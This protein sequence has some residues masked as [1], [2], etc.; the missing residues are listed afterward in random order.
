MSE[1]CL[2]KDAGLMVLLEVLIKQLF[3]MKRLS[4]H[5]NE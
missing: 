2:T 3:L 4:S 5:E 1:K